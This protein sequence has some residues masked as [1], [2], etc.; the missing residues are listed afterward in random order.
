MPIT[1]ARSK[2]PPE[3]RPVSDPIYL[4]Y[5][6]TTPVAPEVADAIEPF[7]RTGFGNPSSDHVYGRQARQAVD[8]ARS[9][10]AALVGCDVSE[11]VFTGCATEANNLAILGVARALRETRRHVVTS[12]IEH[13]AVLQPC[14]RLAQDGWDVSVVPVDGNARLDLAALSRALRDD[15][16]LVTIMHANNEV[17]TLQEIPEIAKLAHACG[18][19]MHT[20]AAQVIGK[21]PV[22][23]DAL[24]VDLLTIAGH[25][26]Y[27]PKGVG[28]LYVRRGTPIL[29]V[30]VGADHE[31]GLRPGTENVPA[32]V[33]L[34]E[35]AR[36]ARE[37]LPSAG[38]RMQQMRDLLH[39]LL[40]ETI[41]GLTLNGH[42]EHRLPNT[43][44]V[45]FP[46]VRGRELLHAVE[47]DVATSVGSACH[48]ESEAVSGVLAAMGIGSDRA[49][50]AVRLS[51][52]IPTTEDEIRHAALALVR[53]W[54][55]I[56]NRG[57]T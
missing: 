26:F 24:G 17:G 54:Q 19:L 53:A 38:A 55:Q 30:I 9:Q 16:A 29:P 33:G 15:T 31:Q 13:P 5:N 12:A 56:S 57:R 18:A 52:G 35:A 14:Q 36:L 8:R 43:L 48:S 1:P 32:I 4:D 20:D 2:T 44:N 46:R 49:V 37:R 40:G 25:K 51:V 50:G 34:G 21:I 3:T 41:P 27:A 6:A 42:T 23:V 7:L 10:V 22:D 47:S 11:V 45:S 39:R 28:A